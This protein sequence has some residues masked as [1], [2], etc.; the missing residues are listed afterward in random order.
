MPSYK[1]IIFLTLFLVFIAVLISC[2]QSG[3]SDEEIL[4]RATEIQ[5]SASES[6]SSS[7]AQDIKDFSGFKGNTIANSNIGLGLA[8]GCRVAFY[9]NELIYLTIEGKSIFI[10]NSSKKILLTTFEE[11]NIMCGGLNIFDGYAYFSAGYYTQDGYIV[12]QK[13]D[14]YKVA[15]DGT[16]FEKI[17]DDVCGKIYIMGS[18]LYYMNTN[19]QLFSMNLLTSARANISTKSAWAGFNIV[20]NEIYIG[21]DLSNSNYVQAISVVK[22][23][24]ITELDCTS[25]FL[26]FYVSEQDKCIYYFEKQVDY[27]LPIAFIKYD[28]ENM[29]K[30]EIITYDRFDDIEPNQIVGEQKEFLLVNSYLGIAKINKADGSFE[31]IVPDVNNSVGYVPETDQVFYLV[32][33]LLYACDS[34]GNNVTLYQ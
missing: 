3:L 33:D 23:S 29:T 10:N 26:E 5:A 32:G 22:D 6:P 11:E 25:Q 14:L 4:Q 9:E 24:S 1:R 16:D 28:F 2:A 19:Y 13:Y 27:E 15:L 21:F 30:E 8:P 34:E 18:T 12:T 31:I 20:E 17:V 7:R